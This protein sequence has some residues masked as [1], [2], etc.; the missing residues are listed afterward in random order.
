VR[1]ATT[2]NKT[3][4]GEGKNF[5][6]ENWIALV[7]LALSLGSFAWTVKNDMRL[8]SDRI[9]ARWWLEPIFATTN[10][11]EYE[12]VVEIVNTGERDVYLRDFALEWPSFSEKIQLVPIA[13]EPILAAGMS[14]EVHFGPPSYRMITVMWKLT[15]YANPLLVVRTTRNGDAQ[16]R[17]SGLMY[18]YLAEATATGR[19]GPVYISELL[20]SLCTNS[21]DRLRFLYWRDMF[22]KSPPVGEYQAH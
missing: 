16:S 14:K 20:S 4:H 12:A 22:R 10:S 19:E 21:S 9:S 6:R 3:H 17:A 2:P 7:A 5:W 15:K 1:K 8:R 11:I 13:L 18:R